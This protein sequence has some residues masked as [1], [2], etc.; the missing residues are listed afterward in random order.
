MDRI[1]Y[2]SVIGG[3]NKTDIPVG[4]NG[5]V[6]AIVITNDR[7]R[8]YTVKAFVLRYEPGL[9]S[10]TAELYYNK[11][12]KFITGDNQLTALGNTK[13]APVP[14]DEFPVKIPFDNNSKI[15]LKV[16]PNGL[17]IKKGDITLTLLATDEKFK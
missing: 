14:R 11:D 12:I 9:E 10:C 3:E 8:D 16:K 2:D 5:E 15:V 4:T 6:D 13:I 7:G 1:H 17:L